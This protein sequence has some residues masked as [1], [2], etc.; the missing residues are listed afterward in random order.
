MTSRESHLCV[1]IS[2]DFLIN[3]LFFFFFLSL[4]ILSD[5]TGAAARGIR[6]TLS[7]P[8]VPRGSF[9][10][11]FFWVSQCRPACT[12][13]FAWLASQK[14]TGKKSLS[15]KKKKNSLSNY[16]FSVLKAKSL[17]AVSKFSLRPTNRLLPSLLPT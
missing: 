6:G 14:Q 7:V 4:S 17:I 11:V 8:V 16:F 1:L 9:F 12:A 3:F 2:C 15:R 13:C 5:H 10:A